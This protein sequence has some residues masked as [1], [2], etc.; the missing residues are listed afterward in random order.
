MMKELALQTIKSLPEDAT[1]D[2][3]IEALF[4]AVKAQNGLKDVKEG[5]VISHEEMKERIKSW[6]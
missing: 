1:M 6:L 5:N 3:I 4:I 2:D